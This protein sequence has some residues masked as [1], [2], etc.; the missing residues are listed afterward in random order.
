MGVAHRYYG[1]SLT[2]SKRSGRVRRR[3]HRFRMRVVV[4]FVLIKAPGADGPVGYGFWK[5]GDAVAALVWT[6]CSDWATNARAVV[7]AFSLVL[8]LCALW[9]SSCSGAHV[10]RC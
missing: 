4:G 3:M 6:F 2:G 8:S 1:P 5:C 7:V 9:I 10:L